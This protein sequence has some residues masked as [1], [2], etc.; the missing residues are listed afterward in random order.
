MG[1]SVTETEEVD[2]V[3]RTES[4]EGGSKKHGLVIGM[5]KY[6]KNMVLFLRDV[7]SFEQPDCNDCQEV[8]AEEDV[9][10]GRVD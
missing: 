7:F 8:H 3:L 1:V 2:E 4:G 6:E 5:G 9:L 10:E